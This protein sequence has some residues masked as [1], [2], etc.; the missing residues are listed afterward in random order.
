MQ[1][2][3]RTGWRPLAPLALSLTSSNHDESWSDLNEF[4]VACPNS[5]YTACGEGEWSHRP[6]WALA[7]VRFSLHQGALLGKAGSL[8]V[9][10][11]MEIAPRPKGKI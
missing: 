5:G 6:E 2:E 7:M 10:P 4:R 1:G 3:A 8:R 11:K 9:Y